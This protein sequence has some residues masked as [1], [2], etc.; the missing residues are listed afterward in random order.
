[1]DTASQTDDYY[2]WTGHSPD[3]LI[4]RIEAQQQHIYD[5]ENPNKGITHPDDRYVMFK[6]GFCK[7][8]AENR[9]HP[10]WMRLAYLCY[11]NQAANGHYDIGRTALLKWSGG[12]KPKD[13]KRDGIDVAV[14]HGY[15]EEGSNLDCL[16]AV[17]AVR[18]GI[19]R[20]YPCGRH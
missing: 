8:Q 17:P 4:E 9:V 5:L 14:T 18:Y 20:A 2:D 3:Q 13:L 10:L 7:E 12:K 19:G 6:R 11:A 15:L 16:V 1:M